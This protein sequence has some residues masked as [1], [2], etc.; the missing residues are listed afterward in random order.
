MNAEIRASYRRFYRIGMKAVQYSVPARYCM[1]TKINRIFR[2]IKQ[3]R[4]RTAEQAVQDKTYQ[5]LQVASE[6]KGI[7]HKIVRNLCMVEW[8]R[9]EQSRSTPRAISGALA[10]SLKQTAYDSYER[11]IQE[12]NQEYGIRLT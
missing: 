6:S 3:L 5:F 12:L 11:T 9:Y 4:D 2:T 7:E 8:S 10:R 1:L